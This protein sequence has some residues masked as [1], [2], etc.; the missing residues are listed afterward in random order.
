MSNYF[1]K[2]KRAWEENEYDAIHGKTIGK[3]IKDLPPNFT[4]EDIFEIGIG[5]PTGT[6]NM[7]RLYFEVP[8]LKKSDSHAA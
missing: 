8:K 7:F 3:T 2:T 5:I 1:K 4:W 6:Q